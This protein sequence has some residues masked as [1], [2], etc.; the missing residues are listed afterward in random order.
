MNRLLAVVSLFS[1][2]FVLAPAL[3]AQSIDQLTM[4]QWVE[5]TADGALTGRIIGAGSDGEPAPLE[6]VDVAIISESGEVL[7]ASTEKDG[8]FT[9]PEVERGVYSLMA[10]GDGI[11][12]CGAMHVITADDNA[13]G[14]FPKTAELYVANVDF[15]T[16][17][18]AMI[19]YMPPKAG[20]EAVSI[21]EANFD[22]LADRV[23]S[24]QT[25]RVARRDGGLKG[26]IHLAGPALSGASSTNVFILQDDVEIT[27]AIT[28]KNGEF[29][30]KLESG[31]YSL[32]AVG[33]GGI[34]L[35]GFE[36]VEPF[37]SNRISDVLEGSAERFVA[38]QNANEEVAEQF[39]MQV[40]PTPEVIDVVEGAFVQAEGGMGDDDGGGAPLDITADGLGSPVPGGG[41]TQTGGGS[42]GG[43]GGGGGGGGLGGV[44]ALA[45]LAGVAAAA[46]GSS[47]SG[48]IVAS[49]ASP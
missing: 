38:A 14:R 9:I 40:A 34:G 49:P 17:N 39:A 2:G 15:T 24:G 37:N 45:G 3:S 35:L 5:S 13:S 31:N 42:F 46:S 44:A 27:R 28:D 7:I 16:V 23:V 47:G 10:R 1:L 22:Q 20:S 26:R 6:G 18:M 41:F 21:S 8:T 48:V 43:G 33:A 11:F 30:V 19:R 29:S 25:F 4:N 36:L 32:L 12:A